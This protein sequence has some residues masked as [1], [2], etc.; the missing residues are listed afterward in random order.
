MKFN[1]LRP[2]DLWN[3]L[4]K[5]TCIVQ[6]LNKI[7]ILHILLSCLT[8]DQVL[9]QLLSSQ[10]L[11]PSAFNGLDYSESPKSITIVL[12]NPNFLAIPVFS[13]NPGL[14]LDVFRQDSKFLDVLSVS[15]ISFPAIISF[16][17][18]PSC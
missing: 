10:A 13:C 7:V 2:Q 6:K 15:H 11:D 12:V 5:Y 16:L 18:S 4:Y 3:A 9:W 17:W 8:T 14:S 1:N